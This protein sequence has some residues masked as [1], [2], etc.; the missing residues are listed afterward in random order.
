MHKITTPLV[1]ILAVS[2]LAACTNP[3][4]KNENFATVTA[5]HRN[6]LITKMVPESFTS[7]NGQ[8]KL[9]G[10][11]TAQMNTGSFQA[12]FTT[13]SQ[14]MGLDSD[15][16]MTLSGSANTPELG[17]NVSINLNMNALSKSG[18]GYL[19]INTLDLVTA[20]PGIS[21]MI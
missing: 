20:N 12:A 8:A 17:G 6:A 13:N 16:T 7:P 2:F 5:A 15:T 11:I 9:S 21:G 10:N 19:R 18:S 14:V 4:A 1:L 3:L